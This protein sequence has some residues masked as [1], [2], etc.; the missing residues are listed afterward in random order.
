MVHTLKERQHFPVSQQLAPVPRPY[1]SASSPRP[2]RTATP[3]H[4]ENTAILTQQTATLFTFPCKLGALLAG[5]TTAE[6]AA[7]EAYGR[8]LGLAFQ[9]TEEARSATDQPTWLGTTPASGLASGIF[10]IPVLHPRV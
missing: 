9:L 5:A 3:T 6:A 1:A 8:H 10:G 4:C 7:L 2:A